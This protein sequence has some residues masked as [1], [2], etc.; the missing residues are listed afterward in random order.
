MKIN[1]QF[2]RISVIAFVLTLV[3]QILYIAIWQVIQS[4]HLNTDIQIIMLLNH[5]SSLVIHAITP[6]VMFMVFYSIGKKPNLSFELKPIIFAL[7]IGNI[8]SL[9]V[10]SIFYSVLETEI[11]VDFISDYFVLLIFNSLSVFVL[12]ALAGLS[13]GFIKRK[14]LTMKAEPE[15]SP[16]T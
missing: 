1:K 4:I 16:N 11:S 6:I 13:I 5:L 2:L 9:F 14:N 15:P 12:S 10:S 3:A 8:V 7:L